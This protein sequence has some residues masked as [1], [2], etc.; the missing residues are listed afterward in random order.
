MLV[1]VRASPVAAVHSVIAA[2][3]L[4]ALLVLA[5]LSPPFAGLYTARSSPTPSHLGDSLGGG[6][7]DG[8]A[9]AVS[10]CFAF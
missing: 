10:Q 1:V 4:P 2:G 7:D 6:D 3:S 9:A 8:G 5:F